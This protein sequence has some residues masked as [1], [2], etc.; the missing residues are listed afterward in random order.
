MGMFDWVICEYKL[1]V[2]LPEK[3]ERELGIVQRENG[4]DV[5]TGFQ[6]KDLECMLDIYKITR[7]GELQKYDGYKKEFIDHDYTGAINFYSMINMEWYAFIALIHKGS[8]V[9]EIEG[10]QQAYGEE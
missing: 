10:G 5:G 6:T 8:V 7:E 4:V 9:A 2:E 3:R 1:P